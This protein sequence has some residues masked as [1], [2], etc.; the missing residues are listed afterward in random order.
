MKYTYSFLL[1][2]FFNI[3]VFGIDLSAI[4]Q[5]YNVIK[6]KVGG[7]ATDLDGWVK[8]EGKFL[9]RKNTATLDYKEYSSKTRTLWDIRFLSV[10]KRELPNGAFSYESS[11]VIVAPHEK[12]TNFTLEIYLMQDSEAGDKNSVGFLM[13]YFP[14]LEKVIYYSIFSK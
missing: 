10:N 9:L 14:D 3:Q 1:M 6:G 8:L 2:L 4:S 12:D 7:Q 11:G 13:F 5:E